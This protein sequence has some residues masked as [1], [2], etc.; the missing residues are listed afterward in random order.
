MLPLLRISADGQ[1]NRLAE[2]RG[3][4]ASEFKLSDADREELLPSGRQSKFAN[5]VAWAK[6]Y[7]A[8]AGL[9]LSPRRG[10]FQLS[11]R[12]REV[13]KAPPERIDIKFLEQY[14]E[15]LE[16]RTPK[17]EGE[18]SSRAAPEPTGARNARRSTGDRPSQ[19]AY[20]PS[21]RAPGTDQGWH[22]GVFRAPRRRVAAQDGLRGLPQRCG[23]GR[24]EGR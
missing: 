24:R 19:D 12:G 18:Q 15:F 5:R 3:V 13:L 2:A 16:F 7:L 23:S 4:L 20:Q 6:V 10:H 21:N 11:E 8:Q 14:P 9:L 22:S 17:A 1:E